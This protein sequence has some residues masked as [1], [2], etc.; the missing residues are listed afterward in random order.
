VLKNPLLNVKKLAIA[1]RNKGPHDRIQL[2]GSFGRE[3]QA[4]EPNT[5]EG[6]EEVP[7]LGLAG[8]ANHL[9]AAC[10]FLK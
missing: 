7:F 4:A 8:D 6:S 10:S 2:L 5:R 1:M 3:C 9:L